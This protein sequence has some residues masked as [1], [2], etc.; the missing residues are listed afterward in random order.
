[1]ALF[2]FLMVLVSIIIGLGLTEI[3]T[4]VASSIRCRTTVNFYWVHL[5]LVLAIFIALLQQWWEIWGL[6]NA[7]EW[8]F[9]ALLFMLTAPVCLYLISHLLFPEPVEGADIEIYYYNEMRPIWILGTLAVLISTLFRPIFFSVSLFSLDNATSLV[10]ILG[11]IVLYSSKH[12]LVHAIINCVFLI[13]LLID[14]FKWT[15]IIAG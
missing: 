6:R 1:M 10:F 2:E 4:G 15:P 7:S 14:V 5:V 13:L 8:S 3:L 12:R 11:F 9:L